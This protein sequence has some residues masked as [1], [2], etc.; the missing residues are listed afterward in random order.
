MVRVGF[1]LV[2]KSPE[3][4][5]MGEAVLNLSDDDPVTC[6]LRSKLLQGVNLPAKRNHPVTTAEEELVVGL[7]ARGD[8]G[9]YTQL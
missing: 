7:E 1:C 6:E 9:F 4:V 8:E 5:E 3:K 2:R